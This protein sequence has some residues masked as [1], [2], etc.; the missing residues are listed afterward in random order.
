MPLSLGWHYGLYRSFLWHYRSNSVM[1]LNAISQHEL[2]ALVCNIEFKCGKFSHAKTRSRRWLADS[3]DRGSDPAHVDCARCGRTLLHFV[4]HM[5]ANEK[6]LRTF[7]LTQDDIA[8]HAE[9]R[10]HDISITVGGVKRPHCSFARARFRHF[11]FFHHT[12]PSVD[13]SN[14]ALPLRCQ[15]TVESS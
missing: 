13:R 9:I 11:G 6:I 15:T 8:I 2:R 4:T 12:H 14:P 3:Q 1:N 10:L 7:T 5:L